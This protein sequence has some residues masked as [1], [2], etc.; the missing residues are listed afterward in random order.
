MTPSSLV[1]ADALKDDIANLD[2]EPS[3]A[4]KARKVNKGG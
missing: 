1:G 4:P 3:Y 2:G